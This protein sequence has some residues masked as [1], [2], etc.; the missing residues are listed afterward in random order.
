MFLL[1]WAGCVTLLPRLVCKD[2]C[3]QTG[4]TL[5]VQTHP[6]TSTTVYASPLLQYHNSPV[7][8]GGALVHEHTH[9]VGIDR[10]TA[11]N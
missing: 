2:T 7:D 4:L 10:N 8:G 1:D 9:T 11:P 6:H 3:T 5:Q